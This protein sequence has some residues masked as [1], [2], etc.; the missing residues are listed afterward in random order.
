M[1]TVRLTDR[2]I[3]SLKPT[4][5]AQREYFDRAL[6]GFGVRVS[7]RGKKTFILLYRNQARRLRR[8]TLGR[9]PLVTLAAAREDAQSA[10]RKATIGRDPA[11]EQKA[12]QRAAVTQTLGALGE[13]YIEKHAKRK[14]RSWRADA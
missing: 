9:Y 1:P 12:A 10:L 2:K 4:P 3:A 5:G 6:P 14:K 11:A 8:Q 13:L 7:P